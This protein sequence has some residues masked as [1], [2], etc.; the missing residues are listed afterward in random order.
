MIMVIMAMAT[1][2]K[3]SNAKQTPPGIREGFAVEVWPV[4]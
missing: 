4:Q 2:T 1:T 3:T